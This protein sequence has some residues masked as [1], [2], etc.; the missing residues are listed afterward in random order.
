MSDDERGRVLDLLRK[1]GWNA[2]SFQ[3]L[4]EGFHYAFDEAAEGCVAYV[5]T[6]SAWVVAGAPIASEGESAA[7]AQ[8]FVERGRSARKRVGFFAVE[9]RFRASAGLPSLRIGEQAMWDPTEWESSIRASKN[10]REQLRRARAK[11]VLARCSSR[12]GDRRWRLPGARR[13]RAAH[14][15]MAGLPW[16]GSDGVSGRRPTV[17]IPGRAP[18]HRRREG[19]KRRRVPRG[20]S[21]LCA[22]RVAPRRLASQTP[23]RQIVS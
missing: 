3:V 10:L 9:D 18:L 20:G 7:V 16:D 14:R 19:R 8:R 2:T 4:E 12:R 11:G 17:C 21:H 13:R 23:S 15:T 1:Y 6:G 5:D 22:Q